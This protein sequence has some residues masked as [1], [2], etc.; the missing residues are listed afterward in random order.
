MPLDGRLQ[1]LYRKISI[2]PSSNDISRAR[3]DAAIDDEHIP[4]V[5]PCSGHAVAGRRHRIRVFGIRHPKFTEI[6]LPSPLSGFP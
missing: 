5:Y 4:F 1:A 2:D 6:N 3:L